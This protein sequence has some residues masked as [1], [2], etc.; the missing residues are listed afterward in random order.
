MKKVLVINLGWEQEPLIKKLIE[1]SDCILFGIHDNEKHINSKHFNTIKIL[2][3][4]DLSGILKFANDIKP[5]AVISDQCDY[6]LMAQSL[7]AEKFN[8]PSPSVESAQLSN[9]KYLQRIKAKEN[10]I[11]V[12][13]FDLCASIKDIE[14]FGKKTGYPII[15]KPIDNR[16]G[17]GVIKINSKDEIDEAFFIA[18]QNSHSRMLLVES[19]ISG[20]LITVDGYVFKG[21]GVKSLVLGAKEQVNEI[22]QVSIKIVY[23]GGIDKSLFSQALMLNE[24][25]NKLLEYDFGMLHSEYIIRKNDIFLVESHNRGGGV[26]IS[27]I[28]V[29]Q[30][31]GIDTVEQYISD[32]LGDSNNL[33]DDSKHLPIILGWFE[34]EEGLVKNIIGWE[35]FTN[36]KRIIK[37]KLFFKNG[38]TLRSIKNDVGRHGFFIFKGNAVEA[39]EL[40][41]KVS[42]EYEKI[43]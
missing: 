6:S 38:D 12:P 27:E 42:I 24:K 17:F 39:S 34:F 13:E 16:G 41:S 8:L 23:P 1:R 43:N 7:V 37:A 31:S 14:N 2:D 36:N 11:L 35:S 5:N 3:F 22:T 30:C 25:V 40:M 21:E 15:I 26:F 32:C 28:V 20:Q 9:N 19:F 18:I 10:G 29:P 4:R 33:F